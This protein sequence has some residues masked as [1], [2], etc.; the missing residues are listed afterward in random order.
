MYFSVRPSPE[1][2]PRALRALRLSL[3]APVVA[4]EP[5]PVGPARAGIALADAAAGG[6]ALAI[7]VRSLRGGQL[8]VFEAERD[9]VDPG[10]AA[11]SLDAALS[12]AEGMGFLFDDDE[13]SARGNAGPVEAARLWG[14]LLGVE[15]QEADDSLL[16]EDVVEPAGPPARRVLT[17]FRREEIRQGGSHGEKG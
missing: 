8:A 14:E 2:A 4:I 10:D 16:L 12:F 15:V 11:L 6:P 13:V 1:R 17:K 3:N 7:A 9:A 5:L